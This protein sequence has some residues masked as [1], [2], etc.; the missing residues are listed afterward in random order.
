MGPHDR[1]YCPLGSQYFLLKVIFVVGN[2]CGSAF[3]DMIVSAENLSSVSS[4]TH[5]WGLTAACNSSSWGSRTGLLL[6]SV[7][8]HTHT[9]EDNILSSPAYSFFRISCPFLKGEVLLE[10]LLFM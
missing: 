5:V 3:K 7:G 4:T 10:L 2:V 6:D 8:T 1:L 9:P